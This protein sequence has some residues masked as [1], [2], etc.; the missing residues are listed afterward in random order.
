MAG[1]CEGGNEPPGS[2]KATANPRQE[3][4]SDEIV[5]QL[6]DTYSSSSTKSI[7]RVP[8]EVNISQ[9]YAE[10]W[11]FVTTTDYV[12]LLGRAWLHPRSGKMQQIKRGPCFVG[13]V[14]PCSHHVEK[15]G[16]A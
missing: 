14:A 10:A 8:I 2:L 16:M 12:V 6:R 4:T 5:K 3:W 15:R 13:T 11:I 9:R 1:L 7:R